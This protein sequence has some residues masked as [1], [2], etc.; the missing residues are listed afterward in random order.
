MTMT[1]LEDNIKKYYDWLREKTAVRA[2]SSSGWA[3][4]STPFLGQFNDYI[5]IYAKA[6]NGKV[7][8]SDDGQTLSNLELAG[9]NVARSQRRQEHLDMILLNYGVNNNDELQVVGHE[10][11]FCQKKHNLL[12][13]IIEISDMAILSTG[14]V[15]SFFK[16]DVRAFLDEKGIIYTPQFIAKGTTGIEFNFDFQIAGKESEIVI[17]SFNSL[18]KMN[19]PNFLFS[20]AD[21]KP[22]R[23]RI[24]GKALKGLAIVNDVG[25]DLKS[26]YIEALRSKEAD[27][28]YWS[29]RDKPESLQKF[30]A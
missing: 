26:E 11:E 29:D 4:I 3:T 24:S 8:L 23:E 25:K 28:L 6:E 5:E 20:W 15:S 2:D 18:T 1:W 19:V 30:V 27:I 14:N 12:S 9:V 13:A 16:D 17:K 10:K 21:V 22:S 7:I